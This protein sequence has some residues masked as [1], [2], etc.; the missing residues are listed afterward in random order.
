MGY[1]TAFDVRQA[2]F[3]WWI[4]LLVVTFATLFL[5]IG[6]A[7]RGSRDD[8]LSLKGLLFQLVGAIG[9]LGAATFLV[10]TYREYHAATKALLKHDYSVA[11]GSVTDFVPMPPGGHS[12]ETFRIDGVRFEYGGGWGSTVFNSEWNTGFIHNGVQARITY[13]DRDI[14]KV[15]VR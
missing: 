14:L 9:V 6:W 7:L 3:H 8:E 13:H 15:E 11:E 12:T 4:A 10:S 1:R 5:G 2:G